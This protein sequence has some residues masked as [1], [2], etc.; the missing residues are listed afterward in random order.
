M[1]S[2]AEGQWLRPAWRGVLDGVGRRREAGDLLTLDRLSDEP[3]DRGQL[4]AL[5]RRSQ[6][7]RFPAL[8]GSGG[9][10]NAVHVV[11]GDIGQ[12][13]IDHVADAVDIEPAGSDVGGD[14]GVDLTGAEV[15]QRPGAGI[16]AL[17]A[18]D[19]HDPSTGFLEA[20]HRHCQVA[21]ERAFFSLGAER[22]SLGQ[23]A[24]VTSSH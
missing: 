4:G 13:E 3:L 12:I 15:G 10:P 11:L 23:P 17:V 16:L 24:H 20:P 2:G 6:R 1:T 22:P 21:D 14:K 8:S 18:V 7:D 19:R 5:F 9:T